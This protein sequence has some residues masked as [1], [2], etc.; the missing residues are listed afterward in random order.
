[1]EF[2]AFKAFQLWNTIPEKLKSINKLNTFKKH[3]KI[4]LLHAIAI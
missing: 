4:H 3:L 1:M 2:W